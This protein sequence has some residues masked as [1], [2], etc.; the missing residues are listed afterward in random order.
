MA[1]LP[2]ISQRTGS[3]G[4]RQDNLPLSYMMA[5]YL[6]PSH[7]VGFVKR[8]KDARSLPYRDIPHFPLISPSGTPLCPPH[9][10][11]SGELKRG[12]Q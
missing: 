7:G 6:S 3:E 1:I 12:R 4:G 9:L 2:L 10:G 8:L 11:A 5:V